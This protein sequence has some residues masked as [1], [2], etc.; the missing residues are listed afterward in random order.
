MYTPAELEEIEWSSIPEKIVVFDTETTGLNP[1]K[2]HILEIGAVKFNKS[3]YRANGEIYT[4][5]AFIKQEK[6]IPPSA[7]EINGI[8]DEMVKDG[9]TEIE[10]INKFIDFVGDYSL[11]AYNQEFDMGFLIAA[12]KRNGVDN[13]LSQ[14]TCT[15][16]LNFSRDNLDLPNYRLGTV[17]DFLEISYSGQHRAVNDSLMSLQ[18]F[19]KLTQQ[20]T[21]RDMG[22]AIAALEDLKA[23][24]A[25]LEKTFKATGSGK[26]QNSDQFLKTVATVIFS[27]IGLIIA[28]FLYATF[29]R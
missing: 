13:E 8:T 10:A 21:A 18:L 16:L 11:Y 23:E 20:L 7:T 1:S 22:R 2:H 17:C 9:D 28:A 12:A 19:I 25:A 29:R 5:Q 27:M 6:P 4:F 3:D 14:W 15:D 24:T 26:T